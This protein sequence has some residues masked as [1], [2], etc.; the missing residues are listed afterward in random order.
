MSGQVSRGSAG[1][2]RISD[3]IQPSHPLLPTSPPAFSLSQHLS[4]FQIL[5]QAE[6][7]EFQDNVPLRQGP[8]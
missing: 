1:V 4:L 8:W 2:H 7:A 6:R 5:H 3:A